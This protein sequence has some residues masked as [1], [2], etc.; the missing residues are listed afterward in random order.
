MAGEVVATP[1]EPVDERLG[2]EGKLEVLGRAVHSHVRSRHDAA[3]EL[4]HR[5]VGRCVTPLVPAVRKQV[6]LEFEL[7]VQH[8]GMESRTAPVGADEVLQPA[9]LAVDGTG[10]EGSDALGVITAVRSG[11]EQ[12]HAVDGVPGI[13]VGQ[14]QA[15]ADIHGR[16]SARAEPRTLDG[17]LVGGSDRRQVHDDDVTDLL[18]CPKAAGVRPVSI[19]EG[20]HVVLGLY[21]LMDA[22][23]G[24][25]TE[26]AV[27]PAEPDHGGLARVEE[28]VRQL[29]HA[30]SKIRHDDNLN[31]IGPAL[32]NAVAD[33]KLELT[34]LDLVRLDKGID[35]RPVLD[36]VGAA[37]PGRGRVG[38]VK[39]HG[40][41]ADLPPRP[42]QRPGFIRVIGG[43]AIELHG[44]GRGIS[45]QARVGHR[46]HVPSDL[47]LGRTKR[48]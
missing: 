42:R 17:L 33:D 41:P 10:D 43:R 11:I 24:R 18:V 36:A 28:G 31:A 40:R 25:I 38:V 13:L 48:G 2:R 22:P 6:V 9:R 12:G 23:I 46:N 19:G 20:N 3:V 44:V 35:H 27:S 1:A 16:L 5:A 37:D 26:R 7:H 21:G 30:F 32:R 47:A 8:A 34:C 45:R 29:E 14:I 15:Q 39:D 4:V